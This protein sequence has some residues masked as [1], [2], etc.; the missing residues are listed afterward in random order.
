MRKLTNT[1]FI[2]DH[3]DIRETLVEKYCQ[4]EPISKDNKIYF[5]AYLSAEEEEN[6]EITLLNSGKIQAI[7]LL[8]KWCSWLSLADAKKQ[9][10]RML[11]YEKTIYNQ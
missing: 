10:E 2:L 11:A 8:R 3:H 6:L 1:I 7:I 4:S 9:V 5:E